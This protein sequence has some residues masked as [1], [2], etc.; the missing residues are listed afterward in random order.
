[1]RELT[2]QFDNK[3]GLKKAR[4]CVSKFSFISE[5]WFFLDRSLTEVS[6][7]L[8]A[9]NTLDTPLAPYCLSTA[10]Y[11][12]DIIVLDFLIVHSFVVV[13]DPGRNS[14]RFLYFIQ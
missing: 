4:N 12:F 8:P 13:V 3:A 7:N 10:H 1:M 9:K 11:Y 2:P 6:L 14:L 5:K